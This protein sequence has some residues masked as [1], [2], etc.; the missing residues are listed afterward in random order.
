M[1]MV[2]RV[3]GVF[4]LLLAAAL[5]AWVGYNLSIERLPAAEGRSPVPALLFVAGL[6][7]VGFRWVRGGRDEATG[8]DSSSSP[9][10]D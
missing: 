6:A 7:Y 4:M 3:L 8:G 2:R 10:A 9:K 5:L 1:T